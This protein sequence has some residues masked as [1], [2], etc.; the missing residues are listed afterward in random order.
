MIATARALNPTIETVVRTHSDA[1]ADLLRQENAGTV[2]LGEDEL[3]Q[4]MVRHVLERSAT[5]AA[6]PA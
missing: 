2:F 6:A 4:A 1:E 3:A 5:P